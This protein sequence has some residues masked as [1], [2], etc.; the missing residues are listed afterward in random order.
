[1]TKSAAIY[2]RIS[3]KDTKV[4]KV[5][6]QITACK[7]IAKAEGWT[8]DP[9]HIFKDDGIAAS[10]K[11]VDDTTLEN[12]PGALA[13]LE[14]LRTGEV[15][16]LI[17]VEGERLARTYGDGLKFIDASEQGNVVWY[18]DGEGILDPSTTTG[19]ETAVS[20]FAS[21]RREGRIRS[22]RQKRRYDAE[23][24]SGLPLWGMRPFGFEE[25]T[26][27]TKEKAE[28]LGWEWEEDLLYIPVRES[29]AQ[30]IRNAYTGLL[31][32]SA[33]LWGLAT[34]WTKAG[35]E[36]SATGRERADR[37]YPDQK[38]VVP[39]AWV[40]S[41]VRQLLLRPRNAG[42][43][44]HRGVE[45]PLSRI[46]PIV[47]R[48]EWESLVALLE[49]NKKTNPQK[50]GP[51]EKYLLSGIIECA[52]GERCYASIAYSQRK[53]GPRHT[54]YMYMCRNRLTDRENKHSSINVEIA[55]ELIGSQVLLELFKGSLSAPKDDDV[56]TR[57]QIV[58]SD[59]ADTAD[60]IELATEILFDPKRKNLHKKADARLRVL[61]VEKSKLE[62]VRDTLVAQRAE[63][64]ALAAFLDEWRTGSV[65][66]A[67]TA[68]LTA[69][70]ERFYATWNAVP[71]ERKREMVKALYRPRIKRGGRGA[72]R[73]ELNPTE[74]ASL[75]PEASQA[76]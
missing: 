22:A 31:D 74:R 27:L 59:L 53:D 62:A 39:A 2:A 44:V 34:A 65:G 16:Y 7:T 28:E 30:I 56:T 18:L 11:G 24:A 14:L 47:S 15:D 49:N 33:S 38:K 17:A 13:L 52:C 9:A 1:M 32:G 26:K 71:L 61:E 72:S 66:F 42:L 3:K 69:W 29:E 41:T 40:A 50:P 37:A 35:Y 20:I 25:R 45:M 36:T 63:G 48:S 60:A 10:G 43:L 12:R 70:T 67:D 8:V 57:L 75:E 23:R 68:D 76:G 64:G 6:N 58:N 4:A 21:G 73:I 5:D 54:Y 19:E 46:E 51:K 55:N